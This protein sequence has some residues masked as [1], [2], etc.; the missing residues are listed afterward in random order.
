MAS[1]STE[2]END[3]GDRTQVAERNKRA[4]VLEQRRLNGLK[5]IMSSP[6][7]RLWMWDFLSKCGL[8]R[9]SFTGNG[10]RDAFDN[11]MR[12]AGMPI[13]TDIQNHCM[14]EYL[15]MA[16]ENSNHV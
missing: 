11:G 2:I 4:K 5:M 10:N 6:D 8:F 3:V 9:V 13:F 14:P 16:K 15:T 12:N 7:G 1:M